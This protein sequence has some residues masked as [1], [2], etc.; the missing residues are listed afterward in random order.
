MKYWWVNQSQT[1]EEE[2]PMGYLWSPQKAKD[3]KDRY[4][5]EN[6]KKIAPGDII[7]SYSKPKFKAIGFARAQAVEAAK[8]KD[9]T[10][11]NEEWGHEGW[12]VEVNFR[13]FEKPSKL[14]DYKDEFKKFFGKKYGPLTQQGG[15]KQGYLFEIDEELFEIIER[16]LQAGGMDIDIRGIAQETEADNHEI[17]I[18]QNKDI[19]QLEIENLVMSRRGQ[20]LFKENVKKHENSCRVTG[21]PAVA[22]LLI[23]SHIKP[24]SKSTN[25]EKIDGDNGLLLSPHV[26]KLF[27]RGYISFTNEG[28]LLVSKELDKA[29]LSFWKIEIP[30]NVGAFRAEQS[31]YLDYHRE[32]IF[33]S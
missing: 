4:Y 11:N 3:G 21:L 20:G 19:G 13:K 22:K 7:L 18:K 6:M 30:M 2:V 5:W 26:D 10:H 33:R 29:V 15:G 14:S 32:K 25:E 9:A 1:F 16:K 28:E 24:W 23:A 12:R 27:D 17:A 31:K 8:P